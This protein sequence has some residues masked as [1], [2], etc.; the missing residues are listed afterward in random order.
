MIV[1]SVLNPAFLD[2]VAFLTSA[3]KEAKILNPADLQKRAVDITYARFRCTMHGSSVDSRVVKT[4]DLSFYLCL[5]LPQHL[6]E[7]VTGAITSLDVAPGG[8]TSTN[9]TA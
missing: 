1:D 5:R 9:S 4:A 8:S 7:E 6:Y 2:P 3:G